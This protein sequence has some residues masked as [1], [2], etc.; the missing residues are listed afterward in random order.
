MAVSDTVVTFYKW[1]YFVCLM[2]KQREHIKEQLL[3]K[4]FHS[5]Q[6]SLC[7]PYHYCQSFSNKVI[8][9]GLSLQCCFRFWQCSWQWLFWK[10]RCSWFRCT[11]YHWH[12]I[13]CFWAS[14]CFPHFLASASQTRP[15]RPL[16][17]WICESNVK[18]KEKIASAAASVGS[19]PLRCLS[20]SLGGT[21]Y[22]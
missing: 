18:Q 3:F 16:Q 13:V 20:A 4:V 15:P 8:L 19:E 11:A 7:T 21:D 2:K 14:D 12:F 5:S 22:I 9:Q 17:G 10:A 6:D 1:D